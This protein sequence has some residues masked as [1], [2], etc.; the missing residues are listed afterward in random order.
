ML[1]INH[2]IESGSEDEEQYR[3]KDGNTIDNPVDNASSGNA[4]IVD[5]SLEQ[6]VTPGVDII[7][8][9]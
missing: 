4:V 2:G 8:L 6:S 9:E 3:L 5:P 1:G 7:V